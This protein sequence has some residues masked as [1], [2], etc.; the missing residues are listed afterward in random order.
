MSSPGIEPGPR[1]SQG[2]VRVRHTPRTLRRS[3]LPSPPPGNRTRPCGFED[4]RA[5][6]TPA[7]KGVECPGG[8]WNPVFDLR[9]VACRPSHAEGMSEADGRARTGMNLLT[10]Q[11]P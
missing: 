5:S 3:L 9:G 11:G 6:A 7:E 1:P 4:R 2:R 10:R 8:E